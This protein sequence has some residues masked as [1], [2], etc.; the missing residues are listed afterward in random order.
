MGAIRVVDV[1]SLRVDASYQRAVKPRHKRIADDYSADAFGVPLVAERSDKSLWLIDGQQRVEAVRKLGRKTVRVE[2]VKSNGPGDEAKLFRLVN[3]GRTQLT[4]EEAFRAAIA[5]GDP[6]AKAA[7]RVIKSAGFKVGWGRHH[8]WPSLSCF[9]ALY[10]VTKT[11]GPECLGQALAVIKEVWPGDPLGTY[12]SI[13]RALVRFHSV[14]AGELDSARLK[15][16]LSRVTPA[17]LLH[18]ARML[19]IGDRATAMMREIESV[20]RRRGRAGGL[21]A[22]AEPVMG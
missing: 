21:K 11:Y 20:Y 6:T 13:V 19:G 5:S 9:H 2:V 18:T 1:E 3:S 7:E 22:K 12:D 8:D 17:Q 14:Y 10:Y 4:A 16:R 15:D